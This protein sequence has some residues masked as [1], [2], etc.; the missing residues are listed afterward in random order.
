MNM[1]LRKIYNYE[2]WNYRIDI[3]TG[4]VYS[5][6]Y[7]HTGI[8]HKLKP[9]VAHDDYLRVAMCKNN[10]VKVNFVHRLVWTTYHQMEVPEGKQVNHIDEHKDNN[11]YLNLNL[12]TPKENSNWGSRNK[13]VSE[14]MKGNTNGCFKFKYTFEMIAELA[15]PYR[16]SGEFAKYQ[17]NAYAAAWRKG[18]LRQLFPK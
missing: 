1:E 2:D 18:W 6:N 16:T 17:K 4:D 12:L 11:S 10:K 15:K 3:E 8:M 9:Q 13:R 5:L 7:K 14:S